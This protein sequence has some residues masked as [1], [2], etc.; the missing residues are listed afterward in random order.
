[1]LEKKI[2]DRCMS[3]K[4]INPQEVWEKNTFLPKPNLPY[5]LPLLSLNSQMVDPLFLKKP[6]LVCRSRCRHRRDC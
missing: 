3:G 1:M 6:L 2:L 4:K 5:S